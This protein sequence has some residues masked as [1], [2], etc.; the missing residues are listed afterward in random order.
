MPLGASI[1]YG[2][3]SSDGNGYRKYLRD[4]IVSGG[5]QVNMVGT[6]QAGTMKDNDVEGWPG[7][8]IDQ[9]VPKASIAVPKYKPNVVLI[10]AGTNDA[11]QNK[12]IP[13]AASRM[14]GMINNI[15]EDSP[16]ATVI[17]STLILNLNANTEKN[18]QL[19]NVE[20][21]ALVDRLQGKGKRIVLAD[22]HGSDGPQ[23]DDMHD[24]THPNDQGH[25]KMATIWYRALV[26]AS[27]QGFL[28]EAEDIGIPDDGAA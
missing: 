27:K 19:V 18:V 4:A 8:R 16:D 11:V 5:N 23:K 10:N 9:I 26:E 14:E 3:G 21:K 1:T 25:Y 22:M 7:Y 17:L 12:D 24:E 6:R 2:Q 20:Y 15:Y 13:N 28:V